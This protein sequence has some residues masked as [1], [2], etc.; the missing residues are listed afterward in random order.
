M[1]KLIEKCVLASIEL[2]EI[3]RHIDNRALKDRF[4]D[5]SGAINDLIEETKKEK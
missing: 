1:K 5:L 4:Q 2:H 3:I